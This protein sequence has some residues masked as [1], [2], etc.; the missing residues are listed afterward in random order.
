MIADAFQHLSQ[1]LD[2][3]A[4]FVRCHFDE[5]QSP[6]NPPDTREVRATVKRVRLNVAKANG[7]LRENATVLYVCEMLASV[8]DEIEQFTSV[9]LDA[10]RGRH[11]PA[12]L[13]AIESLDSDQT[14]FWKRMDVR[15]ALVSGL[16]IAVTFVFWMLTN[17]PAGTFAVFFAVLITSKNCTA[18]Y[19]PPKALIPGAIVG[20]LVGS[21][22]Y[23]RV[24]PTLDGF[25]EL[26]LVLFSFCAMGG[27]LML[28]SNAK[29]AGVAGL[30]T[31]VAVKLMDVQA[32]Q[33][34]SFSHIVGFSYGVLGGTFLAFIVLSVLWPVVPERMFTGQI[35]TIFRS[36]QQ[37]LGAVSSDQGTSAAT[38][39]AFAHKSAKQ[40]SLC[41]MWG[42]FLN[43]K[44]LPSDS[45]ATIERLQSAIQSTLLHLIELDR[46]RQSK[47]HSVPST[48]LFVLANRLDQELSRALDRLVASLDACHPIPRLPDAKGLLKD[49]D[50]AFHQLTDGAED[51]TARRDAAGHVLVVIG[52]Y[53]ALVSA[54]S[55]CH[56]Q[57]QE[58]DWQ[59]LN[60]SY[61]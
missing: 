28:S 57:L 6:R 33:T 40:F 59:S 47:T 60:E 50:Q 16:T 46:I 21:V 37:R 48:D 8:A 22:M 29:I 56:T 42:K 26:A 15:K 23:L 17:W 54:L 13:S 51:D 38:R 3:L 39:M 43:Y 11:I 2:E 31:I 25:L 41:V 24:L 58:L 49:L 30:T 14:P 45:R 1:A 53:G 32:H 35:K 61:F 52:Q 34:V 20:I 18:P 12:K 7:S 9:L 5:P 4:E 10:E 55:E 27:Y 44:R 36:C 19:L